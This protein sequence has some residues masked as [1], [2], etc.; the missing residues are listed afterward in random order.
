MAFDRPSDRTAGTHSTGPRFTSRFSVT[1]SSWIVRRLSGINE[2]AVIRAAVL[3]KSP[4]PGPP[5]PGKIDHFGA[6]RRRV[7]RLHNLHRRDQRSDGSSPSNG[8]PLRRTIS[9]RS[10]TTL[11]PSSPRLPA[12]FT[13]SR[14]DGLLVRSR[15]QRA[16]TITWACDHSTPMNCSSTSPARGARRGRRPE[17]GRRRGLRAQLHGICSERHAARSDQTH[18]CGPP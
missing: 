15:R 14:P 1:R 11:R 9:M 18:K 7:R 5:K 3:T 2:Q 16:D 13:P 12:L 17:V 8:H 10:Q 4:I 6:Y